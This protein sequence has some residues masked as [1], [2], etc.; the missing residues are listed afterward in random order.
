MDGSLGSRTAALNAPYADDPDNSGIPRY[1][2]DK[3]NPM[4][5]ERARRLQLG[6]HAIGDRANDMA[7]NAF[8]AAEQVG[9]PGPTSSAKAHERAAD[10]KLPPDTI[11]TICRTPAT[12][13]PYSLRRF[14]LRIEHAQ[15][16]APGDF[17]RFT[18]LG[19]IAS[20]QPNHLLTD[21]AWAEQRLGPERANTPTPGELPRPGV[22]LA[23]GTD[24]PVEPIKPFRGLYAAVTRM[25]EAGTQTFHPRKRSPSTGPLRLHPGLRL[26]RI[27]EKSKA[28]S[29]PDT[30]PTSSSSTATSPNPPT[31]N[32]ENQGT[33]HRRRRH[34]PLHRALGLKLQL[35]RTNPEGPS[36]RAVGEGPLYLLSVLLPQ[37]ITR[38]S[39]LLAENCSVAI[40]PR[41]NHSRSLDCLSSPAQSM[42][43]FTIR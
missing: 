14:R 20:M 39:K 41:W 23:F 42:G 40:L 5:S 25:N 18:Q 22:I 4:A 13:Y 2:Q 37:F 43:S 12:P 17:A 31:A 30:S 24:Y 8:E 36:S 38:I 21:M 15:V 7:L 1:K 19:V 9:I 35:M 34:H 3:L 29:T 11:V 32:P 6:F 27:R 10:R 28:S 33:P 26:R 16:V